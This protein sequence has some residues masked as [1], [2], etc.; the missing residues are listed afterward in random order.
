MI[1]DVLPGC[2]CVLSSPWTASV[3]AALQNA[4]GRDRTLRTPSWLAQSRRTLRSLALYWTKPSLC[5]VRQSFHQLSAWRTLCP[6]C[7]P[8]APDLG[9][10][11]WLDLQTCIMCMRSG[12][13]T[14][15]CSQ[16]RQHDCITGITNSAFRALT[17]KLDTQSE[18]Q[19][20]CS[21]QN[22]A[23]SRCPTHLRAQSNYSFKT[24]VILLF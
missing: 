3:A 8:P 11:N 2:R 5:C 20:L 6:V 22:S 13:F 9:V 23:F 18:P 10:L 4:S 24:P 19:F 7:Q 14:H 15:P 21:P 16:C 17:A 12:K 1:S